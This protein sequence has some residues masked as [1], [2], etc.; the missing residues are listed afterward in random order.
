MHAAWM[1]GWPCVASALPSTAMTGQSMPYQPQRSPALPR[2]LH[3][4]FSFLFHLSA[5]TAAAAEHCLASAVSSRALHRTTTI[6]SH[7]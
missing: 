5:A 4:V 6:S 2:A 3:F 1:R 7:P